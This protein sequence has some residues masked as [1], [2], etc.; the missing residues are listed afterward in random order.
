VIASNWRDTFG[1][2][3][4]YIYTAL[5]EDTDHAYR[6]RMFFPLGG[7]AEDPATGSA[8]AAMAGVV[9]RFEGLA[10]GRHILPIEQGIEMGRPSLITLEVMIA[11][12]RLD[13]ARI[14]GQALVV[15]EGKLHL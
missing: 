9:A 3:G 2:H 11:A 10:D 12:G 13:G 8:A 1:T 14:G 5:P 7:I 15:T 6:A 4:V